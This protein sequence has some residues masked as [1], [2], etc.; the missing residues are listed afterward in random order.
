MFFL[1]VRIKAESY[2][3]PWNKAITRAATA[4]QSSPVTLNHTPSLDGKT[5]QASLLNTVVPTLPIICA[6]GLRHP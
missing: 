6:D 3:Y 2:W 5:S 1:K 4:L